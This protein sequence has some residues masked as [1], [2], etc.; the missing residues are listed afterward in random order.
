MEHWID[1]AL[2]LG[3]GGLAIALRLFAYVRKQPVGSEVMSELAEA[4]QSGA[5]AFLRREYS[6][7]LP[8]VAVVAAMLWWLIGGQTAAAYVFGAFCSIVAGFIGM[9][10]A[11]LANVRTTEAARSD[12][13]GEGTA[14]RVQRRRRNGACGRESRSG[15]ARSR[16]HDVRT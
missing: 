13:P 15:R 12:G 14:S 3:L 1:W 6:V 10:A 2:W 11:T 9:R 7:L 8:F 4:I 5:M 16:L